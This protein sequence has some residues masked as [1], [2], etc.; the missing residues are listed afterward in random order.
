MMARPQ[1]R[2]TGVLGDGFSSSWLIIALLT[3]FVFFVSM[4]SVGLRASF[5]G[6]VAVFR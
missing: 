5:Q 2:A 1:K 4:V 3:L 6:V